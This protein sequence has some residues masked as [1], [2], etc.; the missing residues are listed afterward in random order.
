MNLWL[1]GTFVILFTGLL[2]FSG[3]S[4]EGNFSVD[5]SEKIEVPG[6][7][8]PEPPEFSLGEIKSVSPAQGWVEIIEVQP[9]GGKEVVNKYYVDKDTEFEGFSSLEDLS[10]KDEV[11]VIFVTKE[12]KK[13]IK[14]LI[15]NSK[16]EK[17]LP[18]EGFSPE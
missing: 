15:L 5:V 10:E 4:Q 2:S 6:P 11:G 8:F 1:R 7:D 13:I 16:R 3:F 14:N 9:Q 12:D 17:D 18:E